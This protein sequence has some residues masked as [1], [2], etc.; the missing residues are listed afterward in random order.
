MDRSLRSENI[1]FQNR[2]KWPGVHHDLRLESSI[3][4]PGLLKN[5]LTKGL[6]KK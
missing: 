1:G 5:V 2:S 4:D 6:D 3:P